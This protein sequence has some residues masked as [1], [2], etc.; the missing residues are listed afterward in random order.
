M[1]EV[2][3]LL[4]GWV[5][6]RCGVRVRGGL[7]ETWV[8]VGWLLLWCG[9]VGVVM[10]RDRVLRMD[11]RVGRG[12]G[13]YCGGVGGGTWVGYPSRRLVVMRYRCSAGGVGGMGLRSGGASSGCGSAGSLQLLVALRV[14]AVGAGCCAAEPVSGRRGTLCGRCHF[15]IISARRLAVRDVRFGVKCGV[16]LDSPGKRGL[17]CSEGRR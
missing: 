14:G 15:L 2:A 10:R 6:A 4:V 16:D 1:E 11:W 17:G 7:M 9:S 12:A 3:V 8:V 5:G 13:M